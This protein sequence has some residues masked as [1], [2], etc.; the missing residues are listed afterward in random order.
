MCE[1]SGDKNVPLATLSRILAQSLCLHLFRKRVMHDCAIVSQSC[2]TFFL[3]KCREGAIHDC[4]SIL[5]SVA[6][7]T[8]LSPLVSHILLHIQNA[9]MHM[10]DSIS[11]REL[12]V[13]TILHG[14]SL[15]LHSFS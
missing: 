1:T 2:I 3:N 9:V 11:L 6:K 13:F 7:G 14:L 10:N 8:F 12:L 4:A 5:D 15:Y